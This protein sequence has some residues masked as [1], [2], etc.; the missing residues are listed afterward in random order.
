MGLR[1][2]IFIISVALCSCDKPDAPGL[3]RKTGERQKIT[4]YFAD[5][6][7]N[8]ELNDGI[9]LEIYEDTIEFIE[10]EAGKNIIPE[11]LSSVANSTLTLQDN[12]KVKWVRNFK[13]N[14][15]VRLHVKPKKYFKLT[16][17]G[18][19][20]INTLNTRNDSIFE[21]DS[22][23]SA[24]SI[25]L[26]VKVKQLNLSIHTGPADIT[27]KGKTNIS[28]FYS[29]SNGFIFARELTSNMIYMNNSGTGDMEVNAVDILDVTMYNIGNTYCF[30]VP[31][32][33][34]R[35]ISGKG[36]LIFIN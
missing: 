14:I 11:I 21:I 13:Q 32:N 23:G 24:G 3:F 26:D 30:S 17:R 10:I 4:R 16:C 28:Y 36:E 25:F 34:S 29:I 18:Y 33:V 35:N 12:N 5:S 7:D 1:I 15:I 20:N 8:V 6:F 27:V 22:W 9:N 19:G 2:Y 31:K